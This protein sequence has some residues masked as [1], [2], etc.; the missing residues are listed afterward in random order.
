M[1]SPRY[2]QGTN[3][4]HIAMCKEEEADERYLLRLVLPRGIRVDWIVSAQIPW[5]HL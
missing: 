5:N 4:C 1:N 3:L 2:L